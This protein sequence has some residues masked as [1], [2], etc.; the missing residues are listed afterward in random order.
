MFE[1]TTLMRSNTSQYR[2]AESFYIHNA[3]VHGYTNQGQILGAGPGPGSD[4]D[5]LSFDWIKGTKI[6]NLFIQRINLNEDYFIRAVRDKARHDS[7]YTIG[8]R[9]TQT[10]DNF[11]FSG[12]LLT[13]YRFN[14][15]YVES[16]DLF[17]LGIGVTVRYLLK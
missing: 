2:P 10:F 4:M 11:V 14:R 12:Q 3:N 13:S 15:Y 17:N 1:H 5:Y 9:H 7:E 6:K 16:D 8:Y